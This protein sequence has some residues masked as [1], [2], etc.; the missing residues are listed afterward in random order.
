MDIFLPTLFPNVPGQ[1]NTVPERRLKMHKSF[2]EKNNQKKYG[3]TN[4][5]SA[6]TARS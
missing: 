5:H 6:L 4:P 3:K 1:N 2:H